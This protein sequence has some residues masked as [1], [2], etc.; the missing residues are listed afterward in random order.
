M[1]IRRPYMDVIKIKL[2][3]SNGALVKFVPGKTI[4]TFRF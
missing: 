4:V 1:P 3:E 2:A